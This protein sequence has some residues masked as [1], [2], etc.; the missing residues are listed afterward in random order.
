MD[1]FDDLQTFVWVA[2][3]ASIRKAA[4]VLD[5]APSAVSR[6]VKDLE[7]RLQVQLLTRTT[8]QV[9]LTSAGE[10]F[11][12]KAKRLL[13]E[14]EDAE[15]SV[16]ADSQSLTGE[17]RITVPLSFGIAHIVPAMNDFMALHPELKID[18]DFSDSE[19][20][21]TTHRI[22]LAIR[23]GQLKNSTMRA[24]QLAPIHFVVAASPAFWKQY[25]IPKKPDQL[26]GL[27]ALCYSN[28]ATGNVWSWSNDLGDSGQVQLS[29]RYQ[30]S[31]GEALV[32]AAAKGFGVVRLPTFLVGNAIDEKL[33][34]P[35]LLS[36]NWGI[37]GLHAVYPDTAFLPNKTRQ[38]IDFLSERFEQKREWDDCLKRY[39]KRIR[40][41]PA[42]KVA[43]PTA[44]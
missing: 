25:G 37:S 21:I 3:L 36:T 17:L 19:V 26:T 33:L 1:K 42:S 7:K 11:F 31:N 40:Q 2:E 13:E 27:P 24:K 14:L 16:S 28:T 39:L 32:Q 22:D 15:A 35:V 18:A 4:D 5:R 10:R 30:A 44:L 8:R 9:R 41:A 6:R 29:S 23:I 43:K 38:F 20:D 12:E 34:Q